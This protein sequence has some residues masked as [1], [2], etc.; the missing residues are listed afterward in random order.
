MDSHLLKGE[1]KYPPFCKGGL[2]GFNETNEINEMDET[3][4]E[5]S[6]S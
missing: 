5:D 4:D 1:S 6:C 2:G 3:N